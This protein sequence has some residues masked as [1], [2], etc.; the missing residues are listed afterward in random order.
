MTT[1]S[2]A[3]THKPNDELAGRGVILFDGVCNF[4]NQYVNYV[5]DHDPADYFRFASLQS[6]TGAELAAEHGIDVKELSTVVLIAD[7]RAYLRSGAVLRI[8]GR[9]KGPLKLLWPFLIVPSL[10]RDAAYRFV[11]KRRYRW[12]GKRDECRLPTPS[13]QMR[14]LADPVD[15]AG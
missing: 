12:F 9:L 13:D 11:A 4:C 10:I 8:C 1:Q 15:V 3:T 2:P 14:F 5:I 6:A 7:G